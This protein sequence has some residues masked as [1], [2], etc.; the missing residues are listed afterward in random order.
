[1]FIFTILSIINL[2]FY[3]LYYWNLFSIIFLL[4]YKGIDFIPAITL[5][6]WGFISSRR[7]LINFQ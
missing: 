3:S 5:K 2:I 4:Y 6:K 1:M 7:V